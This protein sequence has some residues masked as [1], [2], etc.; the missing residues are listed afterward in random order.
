MSTDWDI[1]SQTI[2][3]VQF[4]DFAKIYCDHWN[5]VLK[6]SIEIYDGIW[7]ILTDLVTQIHS[8]KLLKYP[9]WGAGIRQQ[10][11]TPEMRTYRD[12]I[13][14]INEKFTEQYLRNLRE[15]TRKR[16]FRFLRR[17]LEMNLDN[18][19]KTTVIQLNE[20][21]D[22]GKFDYQKIDSIN[23]KHEFPFGE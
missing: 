2:R 16:K 7:E 3:L 11:I 17:V 13:I 22:E 12:R 4:E 10:N 6:Q 20:R 8:H 15:S 9:K 1:G 5:D 19:M 14:R 21:Y 18:D 23:N